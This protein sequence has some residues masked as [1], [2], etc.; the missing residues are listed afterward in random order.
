MSTRMPSGATWGAC[1]GLGLA[2]VIKSSVR[3][4]L[5]DP[6]L[7]RVPTSH[8]SCARWSTSSGAAAPSARGGRRAHRLRPRCGSHAPFTRGRPAIDS[9]RAR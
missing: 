1:D 9:D 8:P 5:A 7:V 2:Y 3:R 6:R 4:E